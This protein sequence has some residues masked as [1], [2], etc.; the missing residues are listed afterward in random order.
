MENKAD[1][2]QAYIDG[3]LT[4]DELAQFEKWMAEDEELRAEVHAQ[5]EVQETIRKRLTSKEDALR[6]NLRQ[7]RVGLQTGRKGVV[8]LYKVYLPVAAAVCLLIFFSI[9]YLYTDDS[10]LYDLPAMQ[11]EVVRGQEANVSYENAV[12][13]FNAQSYEEARGILYSLIEADSS[14][15]QYRYYAALTYVGEQNWSQALPE[16]TPI[17]EGKSIFA[18]EAKYYLALVYHKIDQHEEAKTLLREIPSQGK[19][20][21][22][23]GKLLDVLEK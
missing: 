21:E 9:F 23:A 19:L 7:A 4:G 14:V 8:S 11:S 16:L 12:Q 3:L 13:A 18:D 5:R 10:Y 2:I 17:A 15:V 6:A 1:K 22:K 20:G